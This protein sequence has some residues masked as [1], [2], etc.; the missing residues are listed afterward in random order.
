MKALSA[1]LAALLSFPALALPG[2]AVAATGDSVPDRTLANPAITE[3]SGLARSTYRRP[4]LWTHNDSGDSARVFAV[5]ASGATRATLSLR[6][7][8]AYDWEDISSGPDHT[9]W[10]GDIGDNARARSTIQVYRF[11]E[12]KSLASGTVKCRR[13]TLA[14]PDGA[15]DAEAL[16]VHPKTGRLW[17]VSK[18]AEGGTFYRAPSTLSPAGTTM[19]T[20]VG[21]APATVTAGS[22]APGGRRLAVSSYTRAYMYRPD[23]TFV[24]EFPLRYQDKSI[25]GESL[26]YARDGRHFFRGTEGTNSVVYRI[27][28]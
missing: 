3:S 9:L 26:E 8:K 5:A 14:Y 17:V 21:P 15:H 28:L 7:A 6:C 22:F 1:P 10:V 20:A 24:R 2:S 13:F 11:R 19:L 16:L 23:L 12:P 25:S 27:A 18:D 4:L